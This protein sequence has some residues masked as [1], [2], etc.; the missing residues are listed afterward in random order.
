VIANDPGQVYA[1]FKFRRFRLNLLRFLRLPLDI[2]ESALR[3]V[4]KARSENLLTHYVMRA[5]N[6]RMFPPIREPARRR[7]QRSAGQ[8]I[9]AQEA[10]EL[11][12]LGSEYFE[13]SKRVAEAIQTADESLDG[14]ALRS[15][16]REAAL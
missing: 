14:N 1:L 5:D 15:A 3:D 4:I 8:E 11:R 13:A 16:G 7:F 9:T 2:R 6:A 10:H 12:L